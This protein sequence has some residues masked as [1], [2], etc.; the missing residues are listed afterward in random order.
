[1]NHVFYLSDLK[2]FDPLCIMMDVR[3][4]LKIQNTRWHSFAVCRICEAAPPLWNDR[5]VRSRVRSISHRGTD[6][7]Q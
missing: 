3:A 6:Y 5:P 4:R 7:F 1:M 2:L